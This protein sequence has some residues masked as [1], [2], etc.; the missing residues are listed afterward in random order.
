MR[1]LEGLVVLLAGF[2]AVAL[3][4]ALIAACL[5]PRSLVEF[6][7]AAYVL[8]WTWLV[9]VSLALSLPKLLIRGWLL[10]A[11]GV[12][13]AVAAAVW[14]AFDRPPVPGVRSA[15]VSVRRALRDPV[16]LVL[17]VVVALGTVYI[18]ALAF[19]TPAND[20]DALSYHL[21]RASF[22]VQEHGLGY[23]AGN[24]DSR[25]DVNP[26]NAEIGMAATMILAGNDRY[27]ALPQLLAYAVLVVCVVGLGAR[28]GLCAR[29][30]VFAGL[31]FATLPV[32]VLQAPTAL[33]DVVLASFLAAGTV[34]A[35]STGRGS[36]VL[37]AL[38][39]GLAIGTKFTGVVGLPTLAAVA[40]VGT[41]LRR[42]PALIVAGIAGLAAG[43]AWYVVNAVETGHLDGGAAEE[44]DQQA[45]IPDTVTVV[46]ALRLAL[47]FVEMPGA[48]WHTSLLFLVGAAALAALGAFLL[49]RRSRASGWGLLLGA[50][51]T[52]SVIVLPLVQKLGVRVVYKTGLLIDTPLA[53]LD[54]VDWQLN[55]KAEPTLASYGPLGLLLLLAATALVVVAWRRRR[56]Q[57]LALAL[58]AAPWI[59]LVTLAVALTWDPWRGRFLLFG[60]ALAAA[61]WGV[62]LGSR[63]LATGTVAIGAT[64]LFLAL[65]N[66]ES[67]Q[68]GLFG[69]PTVWGK[70]RWYVQTG[71]SGSELIIRFVEESVPED[72][73]VVVALP[74]NHQIH[75]YFGQTL[76]RHISLLPV[77]GGIPPPDTEWLVRAPGTSVRQC[78]GSWVVEYAHQGW[79]VER[80]ISPDSCVSG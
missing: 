27:V 16:L 46:S 30:R 17:L 29:E 3:T 36:V 47:G 10:V 79:S 18:G 40:A 12:G 58:A 66:H 51:L 37:V 23:I 62:A 7:L 64:A 26:P 21:A 49:L 76:S 32:L 55:T 68:S 20:W 61:T 14:F 42:W 63:A 43:S 44:F 24:A 50:L 41:P 75:P 31:A 6:L 28:I 52:A 38:A 69:E 13:A 67:K 65:G 60:I 73:H 8:A 70:P 35:L 15:V 25:L 74:G 56:M 9:A 11:L 1:E 4:G 78:D 39:V 48:P 77:E 34:F 22:W 59:L 33:N 57:P 2:G 53:F 71:L 72:A 45:G 19:F 5:R 54:E 80:R